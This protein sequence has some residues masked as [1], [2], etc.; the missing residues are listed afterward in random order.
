MSGRKYENLFANLCPIGIGARARAR[1]GTRTS[2]HAPPLHPRDAAQD[3]CRA[4]HAQPTL[5]GVC[6]TL[7]AYI[8]SARTGFSG[9]PATLRQ[10]SGLRIVRMDRARRTLAI[11]T[12]LCCAGLTDCS[13]RLPC[14]RIATDVLDVH[15]IRRIRCRTMPPSWTWIADVC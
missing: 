4:P 7:V 3:N 10:E 1:T 9:V 6:P 12:A 8:H 2:R 13:T 14:Y 5:P 15:C 11:R